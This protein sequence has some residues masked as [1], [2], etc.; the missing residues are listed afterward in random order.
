V[1]SGP[2]ASL[3]PG[4]SRRS[5]IVR[6]RYRKG[7]PEL[8]RCGL[9]RVTTSQEP[10]HLSGEEDYR[11]LPGPNSGRRRV[12]R[13]TQ[14]RNDAAAADG[15]D[16]RTDRGAVEGVGAVAAAAGPSR[17]GKIVTDLT[18]SLA[19]GRG[20]LADIAQLRAAP[21]VSGLV[22]SDPTVFRCI[23]ALAADAPAAL[24]AINTAR[25]AARATAWSLADERAPDYAADASSPLVIDVDATLGGAHSEKESAAPTFKRGFGSTR[26]G[27]F[28]TTDPRAPGSRWPSC[29]ARGTPGRTPLPTTSLSC[30]RRWPSCPAG[31]PAAR[32]SWSA[33]TARVGPMNCWPG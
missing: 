14:R 10:E 20:C 7:A 18:V 28:S 13:R 15:A 19:I 11:A 6:P 8:G 22:A 26:C 23:D 21:E 27:R 16:H 33:S 4:L 3:S 17:P 5:L 29:C 1:V 32:R 30:V 12:Q 2:C 24:A 31:M 25:A 9:S